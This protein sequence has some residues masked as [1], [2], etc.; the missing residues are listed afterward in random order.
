MFALKTVCLDFR[1]LRHKSPTDWH[2]INSRLEQR[3]RERGS[4]API[5][6]NWQTRI[7]VRLTALVPLYSATTRMHTIRYV[8]HFKWLFEHS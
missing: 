5:V 3:E 7:D 4:C 1:C 2:F 8:N 6:I